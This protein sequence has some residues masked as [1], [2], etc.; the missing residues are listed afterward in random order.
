V[1][2]LKR[3]DVYWLAFD[4]SVGGEIQKTRPAVVVS[5]DAANAV[6]NRVIVVPISSQVSRLYPGEA[7]IQLEGQQR[8]AMADQLTTASKLRIKKLIGTVSP[9]DMTRIERAILLQLG[10]KT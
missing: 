2:P 7:F 1:I 6:L 5:N 3:G 8:K 4:P 10:I 9:D